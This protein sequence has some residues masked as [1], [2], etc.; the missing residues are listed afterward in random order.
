MNWISTY[1][2]NKQKACL[3]P[4]SLVMIL[5]QCLSLWFQKYW[6]HICGILSVLF[7][8]CSLLAPIL[9]SISLLQLSSVVE[10]WLILLCL[11]QSPNGSCHQQMLVRSRLPIVAWWIGWRVL[12][13]AATHMNCTRF[14]VKKTEHV[15]SISTYA[16]DVKS[17]QVV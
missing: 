7:L 14:H 5:L 4:L 10:C 17:G 2:I 15:P 1:H 9:I 6:C 12:G 8:L 11:T 13:Q 3:A 16:Q